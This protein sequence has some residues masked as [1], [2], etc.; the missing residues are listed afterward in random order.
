MPWEHHWQF[1]ERMTTPHEPPPLTDAQHAEARQLEQQFQQREQEL[2]VMRA[3]RYGL[4][5]LPWKRGK[6]V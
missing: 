1:W 2:R 4:E 6:E 3:K 5:L